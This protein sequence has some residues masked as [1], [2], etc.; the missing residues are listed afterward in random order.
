M[1]ATWSVFFMA[2]ALGLSSCFKNSEDPNAQ[3]NAEMKFIDEYLDLIGETDV[4]Y[5]NQTG[6]RFVLDTFEPDMEGYDAPAHAGQ[7]VKVQYW[8]YTLTSS[9]RSS[10]PF[11]FGTIDDNIDDVL[12]T[13]VQYAISVMLEGSSGEVYIPSKHGYGE[14]GTS[15]IPPN[16]TLVYYLQIDEVT[17][18][19]AQTSQLDI[20]TTAINAYIKGANLPTAKQH[21][22]GFWYVVN[23]PPTGSGYPNPYSVATFD[24]T[25]KLLTAQGPGTVIQQNTITQGIFGLID[26]LKLGM[27]L[28]GVGSKVT[29]YIPSVLGYG[30]STQQTG[31]PANSN[32]VFE[33]K[34]TSIA[35]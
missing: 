35:Q 5:D 23:E 16:T 31:I 15:T 2:L 3:L 18:T 19:A 33:I 30:G 20:D 29:F 7:N 21:P 22:S 32:L 25:L 17:R 13:G 12:P 4:L 28:V 1:K 11:A 9:G 6:L 34:L 8:G 10:T 26:G 24:Y 14:A 27:P